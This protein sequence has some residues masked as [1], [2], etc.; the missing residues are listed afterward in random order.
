MYLFFLNIFKNIKAINKVIEFNKL[1]IERI[2][3]SLSNLVE[4]VINNPRMNLATKVKTKE[5]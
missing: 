4:E 1:K 3:T 2:N 5:I